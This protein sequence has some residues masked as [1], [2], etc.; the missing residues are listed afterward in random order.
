MTRTIPGWERLK[1]SIGDSGKPGWR[2]LSHDRESQQT[3]VYR[4][5]EG[6]WANASIY[7]EWIAYD[8]CWRFHM[9]DK[10]GRV[11]GPVYHEHFEPTMNKLN[12]KIVNRGLDPII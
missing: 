11:Y 10:E 6:P 8:D 5:N 9:L 3:A 4:K 2:L 1:P 12:D 7:C